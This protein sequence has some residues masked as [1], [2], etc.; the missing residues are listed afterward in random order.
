MKKTLPVLFFALFATISNAFANPGDTTWVQAQNDIQ[1]DY[2]NN[3]DAAV[4]FPTGAVSYR[5]VIMVFTLGR[6]ECAAGTQYCGDWDYTVQNYVMTPTDTFELGRLITPYADESYPRTKLNWKQRYYFDVTDFYPILKNSAKMRLL[7]QGYSGGFTAN[8]KFAFIEGTPPRT[9][10]AIKRLWHGSFAFGSAS[11]AIE[12]HMPA[13]PTTAPVGT[14]TADMKFTVTGHGSDAS[15]C[16]EFCSKYYQVYNGSTFIAQKDIWRDD[17][18]Y[19]N[20]YPQAGTWIYDRANWCPGDLINPA[21]YKFGA[22]AGGATINPDINF[23]TYAG[24][25]SASYIIDAAMFF[26]GAYSFTQDASLERIIAPSNYEGDFRANPI[27]GKPIIKVKNTGSATLTSI[28]FQYGVVGQALQTYTLSGLSLAPFAELDVTLP[29][30]APLNNMPMSNTSQFTASITGVNG[31][32]DGYAVNNTATTTFATAAD[33][34]AQFAV[35]LR[36]NNF[37]TE[38]SWKLENSA[39]TVIAQRTPTAGLTFYTDQVTGLANGCYKLTVTDAGC[40]GLYWWANASSTN[41]GAFFVRSTDLTTFIPFTNGLPT[42]YYLGA[43]IQIPN[44]SQDFGCGFT[45]YFRVGA[46]VPLSLLSFSGQGD[47]DNINHLFWKTTS[48]INT[49]H[50]E[51]EYASDGINFKKVAEVKAAG[52]STNEK[53]YSIE[54]NPS[55]KANNYYYRLKMV[56]K[57]GQYK[58]SNIVLI[59]P[60][61]SNFAVYV[62]SPNPF[63][64]HMKVNLTSLKAQALQAIITDMEGRV[65]YR[66]QFNLQEGINNLDLKNIGNLADGVYLLQ[67][68]A[69]GEKIVQKLMKQA[70]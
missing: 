18:G 8:V 29:D 6:Y 24:N 36:S 21:V 34:P 14:Q 45:Q 65:Y 48:E 32:A 70:Q 56:D 15:G 40:D 20:L 66:S 17:C 2:Y 58:Y 54:H 33:W 64:D 39:G 62:V 22:V 60:K 27:C 37:Y 38:T 68:E 3:F 63:T 25:G 31:G 16:S 1:L 23:Q 28:S 19:N 50:F 51:I 41:L 11:D 61:L 35:S 49:S 30:L 9:V 47:K 7:Y 52:N 12:T 67:M 46:I 5:K 57:D 26:Y 59:K 42:P 4:T 55:I 43:N 69:G 44:T 13:I 53:T 10:T